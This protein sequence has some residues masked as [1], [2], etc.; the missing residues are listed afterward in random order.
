MVILLIS[1]DLLTMLQISRGNI[2]LDLKYYILRFQYFLVLFLILNGTL[3]QDL[4]LISGTQTGCR[5]LD[6][7]IWQKKFMPFVPE[8]S[9]EFSAPP[10]FYGDV[11]EKGLSTGW[12]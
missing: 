3:L 11:L 12:A 1:I 9:A 7:Y 8:I 2:H 6:S 5:R 4:T 10:E